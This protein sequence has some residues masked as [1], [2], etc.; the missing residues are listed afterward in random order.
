MNE[1]EDRLTDKLLDDV[2]SLRP[3]DVLFI[4]ELAIAKWNVDLKPEERDRL[5]DIYNER[6]G[7]GIEE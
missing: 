5:Y 6:F 7:Y 4:E 3:D 1:E 2:G